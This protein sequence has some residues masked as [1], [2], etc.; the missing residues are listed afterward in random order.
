ML[1]WAPA[2]DCSGRKVCISPLCVVPASPF[3]PLF[4]SCQAAY[5]VSGLTYEATT[6]VCIF[7]PNIGV[8][9]AFRALQGAAGETGVGCSG[10]EG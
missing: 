7:A 9:V 10:V 2:S 3:L 4:L 5:F 6:I 8:L 1:V